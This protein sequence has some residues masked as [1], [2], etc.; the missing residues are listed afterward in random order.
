MTYTLRPHQV[1]AVQ[2][3]HNGCVLW[4]GVGSGKTITALAYAMEREPN[5]K[6]IVVTT[7]KV[8]DSISWEKTAAKMAMRFDQLDRVT[9]WNKIQELTGC[10]D[11]FFIFDE[12]KVVG[13]GAWVKAFHKITKKNRWIMLSATPGDTW[14]DYSALFIAN[15]WYKNITQF[16]QE[17]A[18]YS[19]FTSYPKIEKWIGEQKLQRY[20]R[21]LL[22]RMPMERHTTRHMEYV[23]CE[24]D[25]DK[26]DV[27]RKQRWNPFEDKPIEN[28]AEMFGAMRK[29]VST[30]P[31]RSAALWRLMEEHPRLIVFYNYNYELDILRNIA[32]EAVERFR[33]SSD[34]SR[35]TSTKSGNDSKTNHTS[36]EERTESWESTTSK[37]SRA[38]TSSPPASSSRS[39][40]TSPTTAAPSSR[41]PS[42]TSRTA[43]TRSSAGDVSPVRTPSPSEPAST[44]RS[45]SSTTPVPSD[46]SRSSPTTRTDSP[47]FAFAE[48]NGHKHQPVPDS[49]RWL[50][51]VQ[52]Q[53]GSEGW[54]CIQ[55]D[56]MAFW[57]LTYSWKQWEQGQG[58]IDRLD[59]P[60][61]DLWYYVLMAD[62]P[63]EKPVLASLNDK[64]DFQPR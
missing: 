49:D 37:T 51:L 56:A 24:Y 7:A 6:I 28:A 25:Q 52:Y 43:R 3:M 10:E 50:Y 45:R 34:T 11:Y 54:N 32:S 35:N 57:S 13:S 23:M 58:R 16:R 14:S 39:S 4:G 31:S 15:G 41:P 53:S 47:L 21:Q 60:F 20:R 1:K 55:T 59:T 64:R 63:A 22:V 12:Q 33:G 42:R 62:S 30:D 8:R 19:R 9:S 5:R 46:P 26:L 38:T 18:I 36:S 29:I 2:E 40:R 27:V 17:H 48:W 61:E 44:S